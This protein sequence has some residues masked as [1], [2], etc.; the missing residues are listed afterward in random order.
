MGIA[1]IAAKAPAMACQALAMMFLIVAAPQIATDIAAPPASAAVR[2]PTPA[3]VAPVFAVSPKT[4]AINGL[5]TMFSM[6]APPML[7]NSPFISPWVF[8]VPL[9]IPLMAPD[10]LPR[11]L[12]TMP[13]QLLWDSIVC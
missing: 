1:D 10:Q 12:S 3:T 11:K 13:V 8:M 2:M 4:Q 9:R 7:L 5:V 6:N